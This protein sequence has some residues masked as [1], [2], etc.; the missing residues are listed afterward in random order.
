MEEI[1]LNLEL[2]LAEKQMVSLLVIMLV[3]L[4]M[5]ELVSKLDFSKKKKKYQLLVI[6]FVDLHRQKEQIQ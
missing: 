5:N 2:E 3:L 1:A 6:C 4:S